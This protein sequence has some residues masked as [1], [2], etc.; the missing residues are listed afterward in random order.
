MSTTSEKNVSNIGSWKSILLETIKIEGFLSISSFLAGVLT[1]LFPP[2]FVSFSFAGKP[3]ISSVILLISCAYPPTLVCFV[4][5]ADV[6]YAGPSF[7]RIS[8]L[9]V[10][11]EHKIPPSHYATFGSIWLA[12]NPLARTMETGRA[13]LCTQDVRREVKHLPPQRPL[14]GEMPAI[15]WMAGRLPWRALNARTTIQAIRQR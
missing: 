12:R 10:A 14:S 11:W 2:G 1:R 8:P 4:T 6:S 13:S 5:K 3:R 7:L 9:S 15:L